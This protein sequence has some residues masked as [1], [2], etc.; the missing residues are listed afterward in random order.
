M[1]FSRNSARPPEVYQFTIENC[2][3][4]SLT[5]HLLHIS[6]SHSHVI[7][8]SAPANI[9]PLQR[10]RRFFEKNI[11]YVSLNYNSAYLVC[12]FSLYMFIPLPGFSV[13]R[14]RFPHLVPAVQVPQHRWGEVRRGK[15]QQRRRRQLE[16]T[17]AP[18]TWPNGLRG[19]GKC[20]THGLIVVN[21][22][23]N[24]VVNIVVTN[25]QSWLVIDKS[26]SC[27]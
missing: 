27:S 14:T 12:H 17:A 21:V 7:K 11:S 25:C 16:V 13:F 9:L 8:L 3:S 15:A 10:E 5:V 22:V 1:G 24:I 4:I 18:Q 20:F 23:V 19:S 2:T 26:G 6:I